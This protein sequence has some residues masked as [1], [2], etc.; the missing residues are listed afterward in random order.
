MP[1]PHNLHAEQALRELHRAVGCA[2]HT[3]LAA[4]AGFGAGIVVLAALAIWWLT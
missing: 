4:G 2:V 1:H 3:L